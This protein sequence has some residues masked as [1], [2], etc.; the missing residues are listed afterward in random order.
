MKCIGE[1]V[2]NLIFLQKIQEKLS[3]GNVVIEIYEKNYSQ[4][5]IC[6]NVSGEKL[7]RPIT[8]VDM[9]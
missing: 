2:G 8:V 4:T 7:C 3:C 6:G 5:E 1:S 9:E